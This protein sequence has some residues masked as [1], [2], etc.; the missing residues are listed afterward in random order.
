MATG[1]GA[2]REREEARV[3]GHQVNLVSEAPGLRGRS[4]RE[5]QAREATQHPGSSKVEQMG[6]GRRRGQT[7]TG[8]GHGSRPVGAARPSQV[9]CVCF[10]V[11]PPWADSVDALSCRVVGTGGRRGR[12]LSL[13]ERL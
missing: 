13:Q 1:T 2:F 5:G 4:P 3:R 8:S 6:V 9:D 10:R 12:P 7:Y 11:S